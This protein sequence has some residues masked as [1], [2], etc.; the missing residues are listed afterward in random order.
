[1]LSLR[2]AMVPTEIILSSKTYEEIVAEQN[3]LEL[4]TDGNTRLMLEHHFSI[5]ISIR[6]ENT[7][8]ITAKE[9][10]PDRCPICGRRIPF[11]R[12]MIERLE[13]RATNKIRCPLGH[14]YEGQIKIYYLN[15]LQMEEQPQESETIETCPECDSKNIQYLGPSEVFC[16]DCEWDNDML[17]RF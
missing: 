1:M 3:L 17:P 12:E 14:R 6:D 9:L 13:S 4:D 5:P 11:L 7:D 15:I 8:V 10:Y 2:G 16:L